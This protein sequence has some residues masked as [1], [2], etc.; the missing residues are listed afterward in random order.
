MSVFLYLVVVGFVGKLHAQEFAL[1]ILR[2]LHA[3]S[4][5]RLLFLLKLADSFTLYLGKGL[6]AP[7]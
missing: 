3:L 6:D 4:V 7:A 1:A 5:F 2:F